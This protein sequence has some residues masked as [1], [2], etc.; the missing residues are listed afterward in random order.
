MP[1]PPGPVSDQLFH[2][3]LALVDGP[4]HG[5]GIIQE[6]DARTKG[7][8]KLGAS[9]LYS[10]IKRIRAWGWVEEVRSKDSGDDPRRRYYGLTTEGRRVVRSEARRLEALVRHARAKDV[11]PGRTG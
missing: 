8:L 6:V 9:T 5:Y 3:L 1:N 7:A 10:A 4:C 11:L 2:I